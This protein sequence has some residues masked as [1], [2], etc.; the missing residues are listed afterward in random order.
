MQGE[1]GAGNLSAG[2]E[3]N[4]QGEEEWRMPALA[5]TGKPPYT[6]RSN[7]PRAT[8]FEEI[9]TT[10]T[11]AFYEAL[12]KAAGGERLSMEEGLALLE[13]DDLPA[14]LRGTTPRYF[15]DPEQH[16]ADE[17]LF[18]FGPFGLETRRKGVSTER[19]VRTVQQQIKAE[20]KRIL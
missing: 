6:P 9:M 10:A 1:C 3:I 17:E 14:A 18:S 15:D 12:E 16:V 8:G 4:G 13:G 2:M 19:F 5:R 7:S 20:L 11:S